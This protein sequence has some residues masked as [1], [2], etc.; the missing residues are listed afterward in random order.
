MRKGLR[1]TLT[2]IGLILALFAVGFVVWGETPAQPMPEA[3]AALQ[4]DAR[5]TVTSGQLLVFTPVANQSTTGFIIYP[6]GRVDYRAYA[7]AAHQ[8][9]AQGYLVVIARM[10]LN[11]AIFGVN[12]AQEV[13]A[14]YPQIRHWA[15]GG[16]SLGGAMAATFGNTHPGAVQGLALW[17]AYP[18]ASDDLS[19]SGLQVVSIFGSL[20]G[21]ATGDKIDA[22]RPLLPADTTWMKISGG[23]HAQFGWY[24]DQAGD[25]PASISRSDQQAQMVAATLGML[26]RLK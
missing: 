13:Q 7:P 26:E 22:S 15:I 8:I 20:D 16:H 19:H 18:A 25:N 3:L 21:L 4:S 14:A 1:I 2:L 5:V 24:G 23:D 10:P 9:A 12:S 17:A 6:G 11:L